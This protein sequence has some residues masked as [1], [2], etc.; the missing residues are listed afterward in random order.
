MKFGGFGYSE[1]FG[2]CNS[3]SAGE[4]NKYK[5]PQNIH[6]KETAKNLQMLAVNVSKPK[7]TTM[8]DIENQECYWSIS[9]GLLYTIG[10]FVPF[11]A[12]N[13]CSFSLHFSVKQCVVNTASDLGVHQFD[14]CQLY[15]KLLMLSGSYLIFTG[16]LV[17]IEWAG[18]YG[19]SDDK[20]ATLTVI[21]YNCYIWIY[22]VNVLG[23]H[24]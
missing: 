4:L 20:L 12:I 18:S 9:S 21:G 17:P 8:A 24:L 11:V 5:L 23:K 3:I 14:S 15:K 22:A 13:I 19:L 2:M 16:F 10:F 1:Q 7:H 6:P